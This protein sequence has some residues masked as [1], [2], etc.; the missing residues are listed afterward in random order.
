MTTEQ[1]DAVERLRALEGSPV[2]DWRKPSQAV[3]DMMTIS[4][5]CLSEHAADDWE[6]V[7]EDWLRSVGFK[8]ESWHPFQLDCESEI[9]IQCGHDGLVLGH[10]SDEWDVKRDPT[11][12]DVR[13]LCAALGVTLK[14]RA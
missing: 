1:S 9:D 8:R 13:R 14:E 4:E 2:T 11:R 12:G 5:L 3:M 7:T 10:R 6:P